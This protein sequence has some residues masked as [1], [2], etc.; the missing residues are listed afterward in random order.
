MEMT[1]PDDP[2]FEIYLQNL[3][4]DVCFDTLTQPSSEARFQYVDADEFAQLAHLVSL[5]SIFF[6]ACKITF[7]VTETGNERVGH[8][9]QEYEDNN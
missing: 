6:T 1:N 5:R 2:R 9:V 3:A 7:C 8:Q 4:N